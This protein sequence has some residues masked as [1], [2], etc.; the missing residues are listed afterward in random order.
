M[1]DILGQS[2]RDLKYTLY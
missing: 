2:N 1:T